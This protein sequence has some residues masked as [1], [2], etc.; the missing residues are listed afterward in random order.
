MPTHSSRNPDSPIASSAA[1]CGLA[2]GQSLGLMILLMSSSGLQ[3]HESAPELAPGLRLSAA[4]VVSL[5]DAD[6]PIPMARR[7]G[8][9][10]NGVVPD[11]R[12]GLGIEHATIAAD[13]QLALAR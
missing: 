3:A 2:A 10:G 13:W 8:V 1:G 11:D 4:A 12:E 5:V 9:L 7:P 6:N